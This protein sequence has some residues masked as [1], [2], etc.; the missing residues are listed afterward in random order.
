MKICAAL[1]ADPQ[2]A[3]SVMPPEGSLDDPTPAGK[4]FA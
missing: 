4:P 3:K 2:S 1:V